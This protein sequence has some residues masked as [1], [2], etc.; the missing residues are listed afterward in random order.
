[1]NTFM[2][3]TS[4]KRILTAALCVGAVGLA[5]AQEQKPGTPGAQPPTYSRPSPSTANQQA[6][7]PQQFAQEAA[8]SGLKEIRLSQM[9]VQKAQNSEVRQFAEQIVQDHT[10][11]NQELTQ[12]AQRKGITLPSTNASE[13]SSRTGTSDREYARERQTQTQTPGRSATRPEREPILPGQT[14][15]R[16]QVRTSPGQTVTQGQD[17]HAVQR[18]ESLSG[19]E[20]ERAYVSQM[21]QDHGKSVQ[22]FEKASQSLQ[23]QE[24]KQFASDTLPKL[25]EHHHMAQQ[26][27]GKIG[28]TEDRSGD[29]Q[30][31]QPGQ[32]QD[33]GQ[34]QRQPGQQPEQKSND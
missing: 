3:S 34:Q 30:Q 23:D 14:Q 4:R 10:K 17:Q 25:R 13:L 20:F 26:L 16:E 7:T 11:I 21:V 32:K 12:I 5:T 24:L 28:G 9:A 27:V 6:M 18:L 31:Q 22:K 15:D 29:A 2:Q 33:P 19:T 1:M 8:L